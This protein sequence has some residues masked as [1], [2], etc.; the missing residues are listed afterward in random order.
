MKHN[1]FYFFIT[2]LVFV[3][4]GSPPALVECSGDAAADVLGGSGVVNP[5]KKPLWSLKKDQIGRFLDSE[6]DDDDDS[7]EDEDSDSED[8]SSSLDYDEDGNALEDDTSLYTNQGSSAAWNATD[9]SELDCT[10]Y[11]SIQTWGGRVTFREALNP[12]DQ[13]VTVEMAFQGHAYVSI[14]LASNGKMNHN[15]AVI[16]LPEGSSSKT[17]PGK[18][19]MSAESLS[20]VQL[21]EDPM[22][23]TL[24]D[25]FIEQNDTHTTMRFTQNL[26]DPLY[27]KET[28]VQAKAHNEV[29]WA[30]GKRNTLGMH[31]KHG[32]FKLMLTPCLMNGEEPPPSFV[33]NS[34]VGGESSKGDN[35][36]RIWLLHGILM[37]FGWAVFLPLVSFPVVCEEGNTPDSPPPHDSQHSARFQ[38]IGASLLRNVFP[39]KSSSS[40][41][42]FV[43]HQG[44]VAA[45][46]FCIMVALLLA[47]GN[48]GLNGLKHFDISKHES[49]GYLLFLMTV[50]QMVSG[51]LRPSGQAILSHSNRK[52]NKIG[53]DSPSY[54]A[55]DTES[56]S[57]GLSGKFPSDEDRVAPR[58]I[59]GQDDSPNNKNNHKSLGRMVWE[60][61]HRYMGFLLWPLAWYTCH[62]GLEVFRIHEEGGR[63]MP[64]F[65]L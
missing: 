53:G 60:F 47:A 32:R 40:G 43:F 22:Y 29:I 24:T 17:N 51:Y 56:P 59:Q 50:L 11:R 63:A 45:A 41:S 62:T 21:I 28:Q 54:P 5:T 33:A 16:G 8:S 48:A 14:T 7:T 2:I 26:L 6:D 3:L 27:R 13:T 52:N 19:Y 25:Q 42:W 31:Q 57:N 12:V 36:K 65:F 20:G 58:S 15:T 18:Y 30:I 10:L 39:G 55:G 46:M 1:H 37:T 49:F 64:V 34:V 61:Q 38:A 23:Q 4:A 35:Q 44:F 9:T